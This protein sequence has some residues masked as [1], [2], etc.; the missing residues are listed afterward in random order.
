MLEPRLVIDGNGYKNFKDAKCQ[1]QRHKIIIKKKG[2]I[3]GS[4]HDG[5]G[6]GKC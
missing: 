3:F 6:N 1:G 4:K 5:R 2:H